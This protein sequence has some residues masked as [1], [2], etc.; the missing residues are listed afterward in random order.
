MLIV[1]FSLILNEF[2]W[3]PKQPDDSKE[4]LTLPS[5][6]EQNGYRHILT[7]HLQTDAVERNARHTSVLVDAFPHIRRHTVILTSKWQSLGHESV[8]CI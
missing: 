4:A 8:V 5:A 1:F 7:S 3:L 6:L 2:T